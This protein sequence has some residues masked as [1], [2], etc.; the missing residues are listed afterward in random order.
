MNSQAVVY[1]I[2]IRNNRHRAHRGDRNRI[3]GIDRAC[4]EARDADVHECTEEEK[5]EEEDDPALH[6]RMIAGG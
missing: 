3:S 6:G 2:R 4:V 1:P 5:D